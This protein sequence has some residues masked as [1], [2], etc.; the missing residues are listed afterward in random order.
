MILLLMWVMK[1]IA[2]FPLYMCYLLF[3]VL[4]S[5]FI[6]LFCKPKEEKTTEVWYFF[7]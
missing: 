4:L 6:W 3:K 7:V 2:I 5:P 1:M